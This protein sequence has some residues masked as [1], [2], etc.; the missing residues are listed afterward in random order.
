MLKTVKPKGAYALL[1]TM[2]NSLFKIAVETDKSSRHDI[3]TVRM[4]GFSFADVDFSSMSFTTDSDNIV[5]LPIKEKKWKWLKVHLY[6]P[7]KRFGIG[8]LNYEYTV[9]NYIK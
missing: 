3:V 1:K 7:D 4:S 5:Q 9:G 8:Q 6:S 2:P